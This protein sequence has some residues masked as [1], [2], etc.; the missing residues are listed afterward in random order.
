M[1]QNKSLRS[2]KKSPILREERFWNEFFSELET[3]NL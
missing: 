1:N 2:R 3:E